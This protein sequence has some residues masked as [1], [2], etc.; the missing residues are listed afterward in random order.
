MVLCLV[1]F[2]CN[3]GW[4]YGVMFGGMVVLCRVA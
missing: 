1:E 3:V 4:N 2:E